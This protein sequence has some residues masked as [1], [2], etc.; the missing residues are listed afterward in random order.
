MYHIGCY[1]PQKQA[2]NDSLAVAADDDQVMAMRMGMLDNG[3]TEP[4][5]AV[6]QNRVNPYFGEENAGGEAGHLL[7]CQLAQAAQKFH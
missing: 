6:F 7:S 3:R 1:G 4:F 5:G 2:A